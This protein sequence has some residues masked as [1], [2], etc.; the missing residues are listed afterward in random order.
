VAVACMPLS[1]LRNQA[2][3]P[4]DVRLEGG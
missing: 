3:L 4:D 1:R 2:A